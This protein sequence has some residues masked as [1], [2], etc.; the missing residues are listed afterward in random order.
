MKKKYFLFILVCLI[1]VL[2]KSQ[3]CELNCITKVSV[4]LMP[5]ECIDTLTPYSFITNPT[6]I[7]PTCQ[8]YVL[9]FQYPF[10]TNVY[11][12]RTIL[13][14]S[15][16]GYSM[17]YQV[18]DSVSN[19][20]CWGT[21]KVNYCNVCAVKTPPVI[22][23]FTTSAGPYIPGSTI[24]LTATATDNISISKIEFYNFG[25]LIGVDYN[26]AY[27]VVY[28]FDSLYG[29]VNQFKSIAYDNCG[30][31]ASSVV[32]KI[33]TTSPSCSD[34]YKNG[35]ETGIDCGGNCIIACPQSPCATPYNLY[36]SVYGS[37]VTLSWS[38]P[39]S[40]Y[41]LEIVNTVSSVTV[42]SIP[43]ASSPF[44]INLVDG[45]YKFR[46]K[47]KCGYET[48][49]W[50]TYKPFVVNTAHPWC[51]EPYNLSYLINGSTAKLSWSGSA[52]LY[53]LE[54]INTWTNAI[55]LSDLHA[56]SPYYVYNLPD[57][58]YSFR[59]KSL[60]NYSYSEWS[61]SVPFSIHDYHPVP[62]TCNTPTYLITSV[63]GDEAHLSWTGNAAQ[64]QLQIEDA[65]T[66]SGIVSVFLDNP[67]FN[68][69]LVSGD[70]RWRVRCYCGNN[71]SEWS[72]W[73][74]FTI[75]TYHNPPPC[76]PPYHL[77][78]SVNSGQVKM[79]WA[80]PAS[81]Y[82]LELLQIE[83]AETNSY[84]SGNPYMNMSMGKGSYKFKVKCHCGSSISE[85][86]D[87]SSFI[88]P[89]GNS[90]VEVLLPV[91]CELPFHLSSTASD[92][93]VRLS[94][95]GVSAK[96]LLEVEALNNTKS[97]ALDVSTP[98]YNTTLK[99][100][101][102]KFRVK[103]Q[104]EDKTGDW[105]AWTYFTLGIESSSEGLPKIDSTCLNI[106]ALNLT[107]A[108]DSAITLR[109]S[110]RD[111][112]TLYS[113]E[114]KS[115]FAPVK[116]QFKVVGFR[117]SVIRVS[118]LMP[119]T[120]YT[121][122]F[123]ANCG[124]GASAKTWD[125]HTVTLTKLPTPEETVSKLSCIKP[126]GPSVKV[127]STA[128]AHFS[129]LSVP[130]GRNYFVEILSLDG[131]PAYSKKVTLSYLNDYE[132]SDL[133]A[134][135]TYTFRVDAE[136]YF[137][138]S[139]YSNLIRFT[140]PSDVNSLAKLESR[141]VPGFMNLTLFP[142]PART[143]VNIRFERPVPKMD[144]VQIIN[145]QGQVIRDLSKSIWNQSNQVSLDGIRPGIYFIKARSHQSS[146]VQKLIVE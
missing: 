56:I 34:G 64:Y 67:Y 141:S 108:G 144:Q 54:V 113:I 99:N 146:M 68:T 98:Y 27:S 14:L 15:H 53:H 16:A 35:S 80:G 72:S 139:G 128:K 2:G 132:V 97:I 123:K 105:T 73:K 37:D 23:S 138:K 78:S 31:T 43:A 19:N 129:W 84:K 62:P 112:H 29:S 126:S 143:L 33:I 71:Y 104:C 48:S 58:Y 76:D 94:W 75:P 44:H 9:K 55:I 93:D 24:T 135:G 100:G 82:D 17:T 45:S 36:A 30:D 60:C 32:I 96:Y 57:G 63:V 3:N 95:S 38:G 101:T 39:A 25:F 89:S 109:W 5:N 125:F 65:N 115:E 22:T 137:S 110:P 88:V 86:S 79:T 103:S 107:Y 133:V 118:G 120:Q 85:W 122:S 136:C 40:Y 92:L 59:V 6:P 11:T 102:Y 83:T 69:H 26:S 91:P 106:A 70:Y 52:S 41:L 142:N 42:V 127:L 111:L 28:K 12:P 130:R 121:V 49:S 8:A 90:P 116:Y 21:V 134:G 51:Y 10:G 140:M 47:S 46:V 13:D 50:S 87:W 66:Y 4:S 114:I 124:N 20:S 131:T 18:F 145:I 74:T 77:A 119:N 7:S 1:F 117:D 81:E 61:P